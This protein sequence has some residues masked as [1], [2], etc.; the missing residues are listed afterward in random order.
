MNK[1]KYKYIITEVQVFTKT[2]PAI[3]K[4]YTMKVPTELHGIQL[5]MIQ[6]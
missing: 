3:D 6:F 2:T 4:N 5:N 1:M